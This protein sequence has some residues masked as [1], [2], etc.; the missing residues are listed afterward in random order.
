MPS[1]YAS[2]K[3]FHGIKRM[4]T[5]TEGHFSTININTA[6]TLILNGSLI[7]SVSLEFGLQEFLSNKFHLFLFLYL[8]FVTVRCFQKNFYNFFEYQAF[9]QRLHLFERC[10]LVRQ[11][12]HQ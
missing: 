12:Y 5:Y 10:Y 6:F 2:I 7:H 8:S 4:S 1:V 11:K 9:H 3:L